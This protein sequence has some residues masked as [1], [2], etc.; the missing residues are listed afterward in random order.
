MG[1]KRLSAE[2]Q[3]FDLAVAPKTCPEQSA[4]NLGLGFCPYNKILLLS[5]TIVTGDTLVT[6]VVEAN[7]EQW[8][9]SNSDLRRVRDS[10]QVS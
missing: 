5:T 4:N 3:R 10:F 8:K 9:G 6:L 7:D 1:G 2:S